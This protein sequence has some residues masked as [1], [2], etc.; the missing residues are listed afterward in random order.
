M[1]SSIP[2]SNDEACKTGKTHFTSLM[3]DEEDTR[4]KVL[5][6]RKF[7]RQKMNSLY[8]QRRLL[9]RRKPKIRRQAKILGK[10]LKLGEDTS[11][12]QKYQ[13]QIIAG[14]IKS[15][16]KA[17][18][19]QQE[20]G[21]DRQK[22]LH[23]KEILRQTFAQMDTR[24]PEEIKEK[25]KEWEK[26]VDRSTPLRLIRSFLASTK[27]KMNG[28]KVQEVFGELLY[29]TNDFTDASLYDLQRLAKYFSKTHPPHAV[30]VLEAALDHGFK[31]T[32][33]DYHLLLVLLRKIKDR[34]GI[35]K[36]FEEMKK[37]GFCLQAADYSELLRCLMGKGG[38]CIEL[39]KKYLVEAKSQYFILDRN[40]YAALID[41]FIERNDISYAG[42]IFVDFVKEGLAPPCI[43]LP[44]GLK[45][46]NDS[47][48][49]VPDHGN[50]DINVTINNKIS[51]YDISNDK[52][53]H[54]E[55]I[56]MPSWQRAL[57]GEIYAILFQTFIHE[58]D[59]D[60]AKKFYG[61]LISI[62][63]SP[64]L[65]L[66]QMMMEAC[67]NGNEVMTAK[68]LLKRTS[69]PNIGRAYGQ[70][71]EYCAKW[72]RFK[73]LWV[74]YSQSLDQEIILSEKTYRHM[75]LAYCQEGY[76]TD[77]LSLYRKSKLLGYFRKDLYL[78]NLLARILMSNEQIDQAQNVL[79]DI[80]QLGLKPDIDTYRV[81][82]LFAEMQKNSKN[83]I[84]VFQEMRRQK[85][86]VDHVTLLYLIRCL[87]AAGDFE[88]SEMVIE[89]MQRNNMSLNIN[90]YNIL[91]RAYGGGYDRRVKSDGDHIGSP[92]DNDVGR[93]SRNSTN[94]SAI[95]KVLG[96]F[97][98]IRNSN[99]I[100][101]DETYHI[102]IEAFAKAG[103]I[104][105]AKKI[106][107]SMNEVAIR[108]SLEVFHIILRNMIETQGIEN[109]AEMFWDQDTH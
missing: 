51:K 63:P 10:Q 22:Y 18:A 100:P 14:K 16:S 53:E 61:K 96:V 84:Q 5:L 62:N 20:L 98:V 83:A 41:G 94:R 78:H 65:E 109:G 11:E 99:L 55:V 105:M 38:K 33:D 23:Q 37:K 29:N 4:P 35:V 31:L 70:V 81:M 8:R 64:D 21:F 12:K 102:L 26:N 42:N 74:V 106:Y 2:E 40:A 108:P 43:I 47:I 34:L 52:I 92:C 77:A 103:N 1:L 27:G 69:T 68:F 58:N 48:K 44:K 28:R 85:M 93:N 88:S 39:A 54:L 101:N 19:T 90:Y 86:A 36:I 3:E 25:S 60:K 45:D 57:L 17:I 50:K 76:S 75:I 59:L 49:N 30:S 104:E 80:Q 97:D 73:H 89:L 6:L 71:L 67:L 66:V 9:V 72:K 87:C 13:A 107:K 56:K 15:I 91:M 82:L 32:Y 79:L 46:N 95:E 7:T 24:T